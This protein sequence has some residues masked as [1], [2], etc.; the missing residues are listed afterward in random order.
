[1][2]TG[3]QCLE[4]RET[5]IAELKDF[6][7]TNNDEKCS[8]GLSA[9]SSVLTVSGDGVLL[10]T[11]SSGFWAVSTVCIIQRTHFDSQIWFHPQAKWW[12][13]TC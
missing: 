8:S 5:N 1:M 10:Y 13:G 11:G 7:C 6:I 2:V 4:K 9:F 3:Q 12:E